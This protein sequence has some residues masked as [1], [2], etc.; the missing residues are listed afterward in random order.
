MNDF[1]I[2]CARSATRLRLHGVEGDYFHVELA[3][4]E[5]RGASR[6][7]QIPDQQFDLAALFEWMAINWQG[8][9]DEQEWS[10][11]EE[12][13]QVAVATDSLGHVFMTVEL[14]NR[15]SANPFFLKTTLLLEAGQLEGLAKEARRFFGRYD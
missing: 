4:P 14:N 10:S 8:W 9:K 12:D 11:I 3:N 13:L 15:N 7:W 5:F 1:T 6:V 2:K